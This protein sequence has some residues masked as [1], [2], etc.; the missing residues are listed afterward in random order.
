M[1]LGTNSGV[2]IGITLNFS[3]PGAG[4]T[5]YFVPTRSIYLPN[6]RF[7]TG[8]T[9][10]YQTN[11][12][13][14]IGVATVSGGSSI[15]LTNHS[16]LFV[17]KL[18]EDSIGLSTVRVGLGTTGVFVGAA[19]TTSHQELLYFVG[20]GTGS[21]HSFKISYP[22]TITGNVEKN[23]VTV[24]AAGTHGLFN[25]DTVFVDI[26]PSIST[27]LQS[28]ITHQIENWLPLESHLLLEM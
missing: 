21:H 7:E 8:D 13:D 6:H 19:A 10:T 3:N 22:E 12:G 5:Q 2:G 23:L 4:I 16:L 11:T 26:N 15:P 9:L 27:S 24:S 18:D 17:A 1:G 20:L 14:T 25:N 28:N